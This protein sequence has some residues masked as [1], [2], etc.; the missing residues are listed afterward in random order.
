MYVAYWEPGKT[1]SKLNG[2]WLRNAVRRVRRSTV[3]PSD[4][5]ALAKHDFYAFPP[6][7]VNAGKHPFNFRRNISQ[8]PVRRRMDTE[9]RRNQKQQRLLFRQFS[10]A[11]ISKAFELAPRVVPFHP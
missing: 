11:K 2:D 9:R 6:S 1:R 4:F 10:P 8:Q 7:F 3:A 5:P